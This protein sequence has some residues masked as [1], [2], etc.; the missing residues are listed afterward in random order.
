MRSLLPNTAVII[1]A[2]GSGERLGADL[3]KALVQLVGQ[4]LIEHAVSRATPI[5]SQIIV[6]APAEYVN[7][8]RT[9]FGDLV[10]V[11]AG[12]TTRTQSV[13]LAL[14]RVRENIQYVLVHDAA[15]SLAST[16]LFE[17]VIAELESGEQAVIPVLAVTDTVKKVNK[18]G[19]VTK[20]PN[21]SKLRAV[22]TPQGFTREV[23][24]WAHAQD[25]EGTDDASLVENL[26][27]DVKT[28]PGEVNA[29]KIT[30]P[31]DIETATKYLIGSELV[32]LRVGV[33]TDAHAY[34]D[35]PFRP[36]WLAGLLWEGHPG[37]DGHSDGDVAAHAICDSLFAATG[38]GD[39]GSNFGVDRPEY[40]KASGAKL[41]AETLAIVSA[42]GFE[43]HNVSV[44]IVGNKPK[45]GPRRS[46]AIKAL[47]S[48]LG[49]APVSVTATTTDGLGFTGEGKGLSAIATSLVVLKR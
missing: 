32:D 38:L 10:E 11:I 34:S 35:D 13:K 6:A 23:L 5:A 15:R 18:K 4:T 12:G 28:I 39:L 42:K 29:L 48:A 8:I 49:G 3:P 46:E 43:I 27:I 21:R 2:A 20:T 22:Q 1:P 44:Q 26:N 37:V 25:L 17:R 19:Y 36:M 14:A 47:S 7:Q 41:L 24:T 30:T 31:E 33:G 40:A 45:I 9:F 16:Q